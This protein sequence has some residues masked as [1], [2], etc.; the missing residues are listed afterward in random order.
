LPSAYSLRTRLFCKEKNIPPCRLRNSQRPRQFNGWSNRPSAIP[1]RPILAVVRNPGDLTLL[2]HE[3]NVRNHTTGLQYG[4][5]G[6]YFARLRFEARELT[7]GQLAAS[8]EK[9]AGTSNCRPSVKK[10][11]KVFRLLTPA[12][13]LARGGGAPT[14]IGE[15]RAN[16]HGGT[17]S[18]FRTPLTGGIRRRSLLY[19]NT[20]VC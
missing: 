8:A 6:L 7:L 4:S 18:Y 10:N 20:A 17:R 9:S 16:P 5:T 15:R 19:Q 13:P 2:R 3:S 1:G 11:Q 12:V 14:Q